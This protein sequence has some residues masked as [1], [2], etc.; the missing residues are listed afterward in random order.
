MLLWH[1][2][3]LLLLL[4]LQPAASQVDDPAYFY[5]YD[6]VVREYVSEGGQKEKN[7]FMDE[8]GPKVVEF[9]SPLCV[10]SVYYLGC[11]AFRDDNENVEDIWETI[12]KCVACH[13]IEG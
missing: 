5:L 8:H 13:D 3:P 12:A 6:N 4:L 11:R 2:L 10:S 1:L 9:Y 7:L